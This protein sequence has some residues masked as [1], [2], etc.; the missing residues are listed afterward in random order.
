MIDQANRLRDLVEQQQMQKQPKETS[1][2]FERG[3]SRARTIAI[4]SGKGGVGKSNIALNLAIALSLT[5]SRVCLL[6]ANFGLGSLDLLCGLNGYWNLSHVITGA[7]QLEEIMLAGPA[8][9]RIIPGA[10][11]LAE[12][13]HLSLSVQ[14]DIF[15]QLEQIEASHDYIIIDT[16]TGIHQSVGQFVTAADN[17]FVVT[18]PEPTSITDAYAVIKTF[19]NYSTPRFEVIVN[20]AKTTEQGEAIIKRLQTTS[21]LFLRSHITAAG[22]IPFDSVVPL[23]VSSRTPFLISHPTANVS[24]AITQIAHRIDR[25]QQKVSSKSYFPKVQQQN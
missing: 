3:T 15:S 22:V 8:G 24:R 19:M 21:Q 5:E 4:T 18:T 11:G 13:S 17:V 25:N 16:G 1:L 7:R 23:S 20:Q 6:D 14:E 2:P 9:V 10:S 12:M